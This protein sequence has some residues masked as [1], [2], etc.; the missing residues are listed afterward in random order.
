MSYQENRYPIVGKD[1]AEYAGDTFELDE[2]PKVE[3]SL[4]TVQ[5]L[6]K[7]NEI[8][9]LLTEESALIQTIT[10]SSDITKYSQDL[11]NYG[12]TIFG[13]TSPGGVSAYL[14]TELLKN[15][16]PSLI[17]LLSQYTA[18]CTS[19]SPCDGVIEY[20]SSIKD[21]AITASTA[22]EEE[23]SKKLESLKSA[24]ESH[25]T[26]DKTP[27]AGGARDSDEISMLGGDPLFLVLSEFFM[28]KGGKN[29]ADVLEEIN[30]GLK[31]FQ[32]IPKKKGGKW[33]F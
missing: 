14:T 12:N 24:L 7:V 23:K 17:G 10:S 2:Q 28:T 25:C 18:S 22:T 30:Q 13:E 29:I 5:D 6:D 20:L 16:L 21:A 32:S 31:E 19:T 8:Y 33:P 9:N 4:P 11:Y 27:L 15:K 3:Q 26:L 1:N